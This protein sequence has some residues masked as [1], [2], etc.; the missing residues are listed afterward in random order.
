MNI[1]GRVFKVGDDVNTDVIYPGRFISI[2]EWEDQARHAF[3]TMGAEV[4]ERFSQST[5]VGA[6]WNFG[7]GSSREHAVTSLIGAGVKLVVAQSTARIFFRNCINN[8]L[9]IIESAELGAALVEGGSVE[10]DLTRGSALVDGQVIAF[11]P[12]PHFLQSILVQGGLWGG[13]KPADREER[14]A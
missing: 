6:G 4:Q 9:P 2:V 10:V 11:Q 12:L 3:E 5:V 13:Y 8:G 1:S 7:C 14:R